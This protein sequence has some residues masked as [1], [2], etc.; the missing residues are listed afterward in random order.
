MLTSLAAGIVVPLLLILW[1]SGGTLRRSPWPA[2]AVL[3]WYGYGLV[4]AAAGNVHAPREWDYACFWLY[5][6]IAAAHQNIYDPAVFARFPS[7]FT[8]GDDFRTAVLNVGFPYP[9]PSIVLFLPLAFVGSVPGGLAAW[10]GVGFAALAA[11]AWVLARAFMPAE[12]WRSALLVFAIIAALPATLVTV[13]NAQTNFLLLLLV[14]LA[15]SAR[16]TA[17]GA[18]WEVLAIWVKPYAAVLLLLDFVRRSWGRLLTALV[19]AVASVAAA[20]LILGPA[21]VWSYVSSNPGAREPAYAFTETFNQSLLA[22]V[23]RTHATLP[24]HVSVLH[25]PLYLA[26]ALLLAGLTVAL[27][28][29]TT[30]NPEAAFGA[31][32]LLGL[33]VYPGSLSSYGVILVVPMLILWRYRTAFP[34]G[35]ATLGAVFAAAVVLQSGWLQRSFAANLL[36]W[37]ACVYLLRRQGAVAE[38]PPAT[39]GHAIPSGVAAGVT[40]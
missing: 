15:F 5:G 31:T 28:L 2:L 13:N 21:T 35:A 26:G 9:P 32:L 6:H 11:A 16:G 4:H 37:A 7:P 8:L 18:V 29:R 24:Q 3:A 40:A 19:T 33:I 22:T 23:L 20:T 14:A 39:G 36:M 17:A 12:G 34:G 10:Y 38:L 1:S 25:E 30:V 27:C